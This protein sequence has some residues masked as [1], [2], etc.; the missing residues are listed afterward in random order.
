[1][2]TYTSTEKDPAARRRKAGPKTADSQFS[3]FEDNLEG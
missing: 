2:D 3:S 1:M